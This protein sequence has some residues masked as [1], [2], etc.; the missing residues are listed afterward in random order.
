MHCSH[1][2]RCRFCLLPR[3]HCILSRHHRWSCPHRLLRQFSLT[4]CHRVLLTGGYARRICPV[5]N[6]RNQVVS[7]VLIY[8]TNKYIRA[9]QQ[10]QDTLEQD[11]EKR[12]AWTDQPKNGTCKTDR[13]MTACRSE[14]PGKDSQDRTPAQDCQ[15][16]EQPEQ[17]LLWYSAKSLHF[18]TLT[19]FKRT[20]ARDFWS[21]F[22]ASYPS[23]P[24]GW[25]LVKQFAMK[26]VF[27]ELFIF[28]GILM[29]SA[30][31]RNEKKN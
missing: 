23:S 15:G 9:G 25:P 3:H 26:I 10:G 22:F 31:A 13:E 5:S 14:M 16:T 18:S 1:P 20:V 24:Q 21:E 4:C 30:T 12:K 17:I 19:T 27:V 29:L 8:K 7:T 28:K 6:P 11:C 2:P